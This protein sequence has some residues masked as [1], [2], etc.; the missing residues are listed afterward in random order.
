MVSQLY[1]VGST[2][3]QYKVMTLQNEGY[4]IGSSKQPCAICNK[5]LGYSVFTITKDHEVVHYGCAQSRKNKYV[6]LIKYISY[7]TS[8]F[9]SLIFTVLY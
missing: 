6:S 2:N 9:K 1:K 4:K 7:H 8:N 5:R 3:L